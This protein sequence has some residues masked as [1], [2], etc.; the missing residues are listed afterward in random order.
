MRN[1]GACHSETLQNSTFPCILNLARRVPCKQGAADRSA[2]SAGP[3]LFFYQKFDCGFC[4]FVDCEKW[5][6]G[7]WVCG[8]WD[9]EIIGSHAQAPSTWFEWSKITL[10]FAPH[11]SKVGRKTVPY[12]CEWHSVSFWSTGRVHGGHRTSH[13]TRRTSVF[14]GL[15]ARRGRPRSLFG[16][17]WVPKMDPKST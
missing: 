14:M 17:S 10:K 9:C 13:L 16:K 4:R 5:D 11:G 3:G 15:W 2:H 1:L 12:Q 8:L 6:C 7:K